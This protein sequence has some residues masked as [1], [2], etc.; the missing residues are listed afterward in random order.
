MR[1]LVAQLS[2]DS[3]GTDCCVRVVMGSA[4]AI[5]EG[6]SLFVGGSGHIL[7]TMLRDRYSERRLDSIELG[8]EAD[9]CRLLRA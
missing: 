3:A 1:G 8:N 4:P 2:S 6:R 9:Y 7:V 5:K